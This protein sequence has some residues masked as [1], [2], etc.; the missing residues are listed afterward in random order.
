MLI[1]HNNAQSQYPTEIKFATHLKWWEKMEPEKINGTTKSTNLE[2]M[3]LLKNILFVC[4]FLF[5]PFFHF[6]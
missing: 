5:L 1:V 2:K 4:I 6:N 3:A